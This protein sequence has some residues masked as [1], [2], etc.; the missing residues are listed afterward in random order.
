MKNR[1]TQEGQGR[2]KRVSERECVRK[3]VCYVNPRWCLLSWIEVS[4]GGRLQQLS[5]S[6]HTSLAFFFLTNTHERQSG[7]MTKEGN[8]AKIK[9]G[10]E[11]MRLLRGKG[12]CGEARGKEKTMERRHA[13]TTEGWRRGGSEMLHSQKHISKMSAGSLERLHL[14][15]IVMRHVCTR[16][17]CDLFFPA[18]FCILSVDCVSVLCAGD[19][20]Q[21]AESWDEPF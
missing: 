15:H 20:L 11:E 3:C 16:G 5:R 19:S 18:V 8:G 4:P 21:R 13:G 7:E 2:S 12:G 10:G 14:Q 9:G 17:G 6:L 1:E